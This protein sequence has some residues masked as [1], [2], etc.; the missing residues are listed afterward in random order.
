MFHIKKD[1]L[2]NRRN[3]YG[4]DIKTQSEPNSFATKIK[5]HKRTSNQCN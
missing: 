2:S 3:S 1:T 5:H 4:K